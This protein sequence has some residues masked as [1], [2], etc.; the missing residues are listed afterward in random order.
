MCQRWARQL[1]L[2][3]A[4]AGR[5]PLGH[6]EWDWMGRPIGE[7]VNEAAVASGGNSTRAGLV[8]SG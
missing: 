3:S 4:Y 1:L 5:D 8:V 7:L 2:A 6:G